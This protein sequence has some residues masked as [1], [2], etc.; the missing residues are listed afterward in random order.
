MADWSNPTLTTNY[1]VFLAECKE[2]DVD[3]GT[4][5]LNSPTNPPTGAIRWNRSTN[6][7]EEWN[8]SAWAVKTLA[9][10]GGGTGAT[11]AS[12]ARTALGIGTMGTQNSNAVAITGGTITGLT[13]LQLS[14]GLTFATDDTYDVGTF[15]VQVR[16]GYYK[17]ALVVP[18]GTD[19]YATS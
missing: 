10:G 16:R 19:K 2:R 1:D 13:Q 3:A 6:L 14:A 4:L 8:G 5:F 9:I 7:F 17:S 15:S 12:G 11:S 18:V